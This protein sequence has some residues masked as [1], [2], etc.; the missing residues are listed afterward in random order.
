MSFTVKIKHA[1][2][3]INKVRFIEKE[4][5]E[6][7]EC[8]IAFIDILGFKD[9]SSNRLCEEVYSIYS[10]IEKYIHFKSRV[11]N[12]EIPAFEF[13]KYR[14]ISDSIVLCID[15]S[16]ED[17]FMALAEVCQHFQ[18]KMMMRTPKILLRGA[19]TLGLIY[20]DNNVIFGP[21]LVSAYLLSEKLAIYPRIIVLE[22]IL[23]KGEDETRKLSCGTR[24]SLIPVFTNDKMDGIYYIHYFR[25]IYEAGNAVI[26]ETKKY[27]DSCISLC[28]EFL[29][30]S[31]DIK[32]REK[33]E[34]LM[35]YIMRSMKQFP[36]VENL[37]KQE[38]SEISNKRSEEYNK[39][40]LTYT[41]VN[42]KDN[43]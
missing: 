21:G 31:T 24:G 22:P 15:S 7:T 38:Q 33:Y 16:I 5:M 39:K 35:N 13:I 37:Y 41:S 2:S 30:S 29:G 12:H 32:I 14:V 10:D 9:F 28:K 3:F 27:F 36:D 26:P 19:I 1:G 18:D 34:W 11:W 40:L 25:L 20:I 6:Y 23:D 4:F 17:A 43:L 42:T 8:Y